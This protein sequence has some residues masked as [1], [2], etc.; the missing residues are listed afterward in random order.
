ML[1]YLLEK[2]FKQ[3][4]RNPFL[5]K[6]VVMFPLMVLLVFPWAANFEIKNINLSVI[7][8]DHSTYS[9]RL[10]N[11]ITSSGYFRLT[12]IS[13]TYNQSIK[14]IEEDKADIILEIP[15]HFEQKLVSESEGKLMISANTVN[16]TKGGLGSY[17]ISNIISSFA[18]DIQKEWV[19]MPR[20]S[21]IPTIEIV[22]QNRFNPHL[23]YKIFMVPALMV[24]LLTMVCGFLPALNIVSEKEVGTIEQINVTPVPRFMFI[25]SK[26]LPFWIISFII[27]TISFIIAYFFYHML[28]TGHLGTIYFFASIYVLGIS[29]LGLIISNYSETMQQALFVMFFFM[30]VFILMSGL[31]TPISSMPEWAQYITAFNPLRY[32]IEVIRMIY[33]K[34][35]GFSQLISQ[36]AALSSFAITLNIWAILSYKKKS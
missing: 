27:L 7:D 6:M 35:S 24:I 4:I 22:N 19:Q 9:Q 17:Y 2:E 34:G 15:Q 29:G 30:M 25:F 33:L 36:L 13:G 20:N 18:N 16:G 12:D 5:P 21:T 3:I 10:V 32:F 14:A 1:K 26:L 31:F 23:D 8:H 11:K 28:P